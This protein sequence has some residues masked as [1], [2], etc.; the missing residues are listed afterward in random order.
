MP[1]FLSESVRFRPNGKWDEDY[2]RLLIWAS[3]LQLLTARGHWILV[4][5]VLL[6]SKGS[7]VIKIIKETMYMTWLSLVTE[8]QV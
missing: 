5:H 6:Y 2:I 3:V 4:P 8:L 7:R 1:A